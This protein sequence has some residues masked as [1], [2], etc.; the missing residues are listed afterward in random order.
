MGAVSSVLPWAVSVV[1]WTVGLGIQPERPDGAA[2]TAPAQ[3][4]FAVEVSVSGTGEPA[5]SIGTML[6]GTLEGL[7]LPG[8]TRF[9]AQIDPNQILTPPP[10]A[11]A[12]TVRVWIDLRPDQASVYLVDPAWERILVRHVPLPE[13]VDEVAREEIA[14]IVGSSLE[15]LAAGD[16]VGQSRA[17]VQRAMMRTGRVDMDGGV[18][19]PR[20][21]RVFPHV[22]FGAGYRLHGHASAAPT[23]VHGPVLTLGAG[24]LRRRL[25]LG[26][27]L[28]GQFHLSRRLEAP[29]LEMGLLGGGLR[30][31]LVVGGVPG[32]GPR[33][34]RVLL[35]GALG[36]GLDFTRISTRSETGVYDVTAPQLDLTPVVEAE[37]RARGRVGEGLALEGAVGLSLD[38][39]RTRYVVEGEG[40]VEVVYDPWALRP[41]VRLGLIWDVAPGGRPDRTD[42]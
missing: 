26:G 15:A 10:G 14:L 13:G 9:V 1:V 32:M 29:D 20:G 41:S 11:A 42:L 17:A 33:A 27:E 36:T 7:G 19:R 40:G 37:F 5:E 6:R 3:P 30:G 21:V 18:V 12:G 8:T 4:P 31:F 16:P 34:R 28:R 38:A 23:V 24:A 2:P 39:G 22:W 35:G 25:A